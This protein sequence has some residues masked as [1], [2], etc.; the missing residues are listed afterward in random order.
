MFVNF[1]ITLYSVSSEEK[2]PDYS[3]GDVSVFLC[4]S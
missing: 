1:D 2:L 3:I 4:I